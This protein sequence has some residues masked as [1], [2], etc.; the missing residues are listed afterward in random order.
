MRFKNSQ[1][2]ISNNAN[3]FVTLKHID[4]IAA[5][6]SKHPFV[7]NSIK[8]YGLKDDMRSLKS[9]FTAGFRI[10]PFQADPPGDQYIRSV[11]RFLK[12]RRAN[13]EDYTVFLS[14]FMRAM[15]IPHSIRMVSFDPRQPKAYQHIYPVTT[16]GVV[17]DIVNGQDQ[18]GSEHKK[19][20]SERQVNFNQ[21]V[22]YFS[23]YDKIVRV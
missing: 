1:V 12:D 14:A 15:K 23:K 17:L 8:K 20:P 9:I 2:R 19:N 5:K 3:Q 16:Q 11:N 4:K 10:S 21:E 22:P 7:L 13:C 18:D 6:G